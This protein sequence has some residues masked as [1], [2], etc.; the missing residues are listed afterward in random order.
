MIDR[1]TKEQRS[2]NMA[3]IKGW[4]TKPEMYVRRFFH[5]HGLRYR[6]YVKSLPGK[7]DIVLKK[8]KTV[9][10]VHGCFWHGHGCKKSTLPKTNKKFWSLKIKGNI[11]R[12]KKNIQLLSDKGWKII[13]IWECE[14]NDNILK[15]YL[16][17][18]KSNV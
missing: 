6:L 13:V 8:Y 9:V 4:D 18:I 15:K 7:P 12:D 5:K 11:Q 2:K 17:E 10:F 14:I 16:D 3:A 1:I